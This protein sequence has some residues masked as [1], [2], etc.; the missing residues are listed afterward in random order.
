MSITNVNVESVSSCRAGSAPETPKN[1][2]KFMCSH[3]GKFLP[4]PADGRIKYVGGETR[5]ICV[6]R[7][8]T[9]PEQFII[10]IART[11]MFVKQVGDHEI[12]TDDL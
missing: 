7:D 9:F 11:H 6:P 1:R 8:I 4:R 10:S 5:L 2:V 3:G 12:S